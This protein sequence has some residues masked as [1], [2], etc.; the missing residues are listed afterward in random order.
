AAATGLGDVVSML[1]RDG[2]EVDVLDSKGRTAIHLSAERGSL[3]AVQALLAAGGDSSLRYGKD[4]AFSEL[5]LAANYGHVE[6]MQ[7]LIRHGVD[8]HTPD[9]NSCT[10]LHSAAIGDEVEAIDT[11][12]EDGANINVQGGK[13]G[14]R[15]T[16]LHMASEKGSSEAS[17]S[18]VKHGADVDRF[19]RELDSALRLAARGGHISIVKTLLAA[20]VRVNLRQA[21]WESALDSAC[22]GGHVNIVTTL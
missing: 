21:Y 3:S 20:G 15:S 19:Y 22:R 13:Y 11:F 14:T 17:L 18:L 5:G 1:L 16:P 10:A 7:A 2:A 4:K 9:S 6:V 12:I 8:V